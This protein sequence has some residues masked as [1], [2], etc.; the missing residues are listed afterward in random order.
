MNKFIFI[1]ILFATLVTVFMKL[2]K[3]D[4]ENLSMSDKPTDKLTSPNVLGSTLG[5]SSSL[6]EQPEIIPTPTA[7]APTISAATQ[8]DTAILHTTEGDITIKFHV[9]AT[10]NTIA[11]FIK[12][13]Q[14]N[15]YNG[16]IFH[17]VIKGFMIQGGDP[18]G[19]GSG[20]P[21]YTFADEPFEGEYTKGTV[22][23]ANAGPN[24][25]GSQFFIMHQDN[26]LSKNYV[27]FGKVIAG[28]ETVDRIAQAPTVPGGEGSR[29][30]N[31]VSIKTIDLVSSEGIN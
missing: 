14:N 2:G 10:P 22:A 16:T 18:Q 31:P 20:G 5:Q 11:N 3:T 19:N 9:G 28:I 27:I 12:L 26:P 1:L 15:F 25:N 13:A 30:V 24:T 7:A 17:R 29:P 6:G 23:M 8:P 4:Q 21:G